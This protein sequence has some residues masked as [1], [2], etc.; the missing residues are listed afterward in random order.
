[1]NFETTGLPSIRPTIA[2]Q[3]FAWFLRLVALYCLA[4]GVLYWVRLIGVYDGPMW[5]FDLMP[6]HWQLAV[7]A[8]ASLFPFAASGLWMQASW[9]P[10]I[11]AAC[12]V[13]ETAMYMVYSDLYGRRLAIVVIHLTIALI[14][15]AFRAV[16]W[17]QRRQAR[18]R[19]DMAVQ[20][21]EKIA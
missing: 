21:T 20:G 14:Y 17:W 11:W 5:R 3:A 2:E 4:L 19:A 10:V 9:G 6:L 12:V 15:C 16:I 7:A 1:M 8:L 13:T 18:I